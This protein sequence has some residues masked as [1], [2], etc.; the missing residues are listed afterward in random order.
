M[1]Q[2]LFP[3]IVIGKLSVQTLA[4]FRVLDV[5][6][7]LWGRA[8]SESRRRTVRDAERRGSQRGLPRDGAKPRAQ[9]DPNDRQRRTRVPLLASD[10]RRVTVLQA[11][12]GST[13]QSS[14]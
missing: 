7:P 10:Q 3:R 5:V 2:L 13:M 14:I 12:G 9:A 6:L 4:L 1:V 11:I 8:A